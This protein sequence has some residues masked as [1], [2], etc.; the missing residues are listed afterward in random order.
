MNL[1]IIEDQ[2]MLRDALVQLLQLQPDVNE[3]Y[4]SADGK[5]ALI[6]LQQYD[7]DVALID[8]ELPYLSGL[9]I[10]EWIK[11]NRPQMKVVIMTTFKRPGYFERAIKADVDAYVLKDRSIVDL[12]A[13]LHRVL[14][15]EKEYSPEL[16]VYM[17]THTNPLTS[18]E[19]LVLYYASQGLSNQKIADK[20]YLSYGTIRNY[21]SVI[22]TKLNANNRASAIYQAQ[23]QG[24]ID[25]K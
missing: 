6:D 2:Q 21:M 5:Q 11:Q 16:M 13:T 9:D 22:L 7:I 10:L 18:Q 14:N 15:G 8:I 20:M 4:Q 23:Q 19:Q 1:L 24:W 17:V 25:V 12:M 3:V